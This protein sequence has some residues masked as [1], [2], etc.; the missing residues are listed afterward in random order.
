[1]RVSKKSITFARLL[2]MKNIT[3]TFIRLVLISLCAV[4]V[5]SPL[6]ADSK[7][8]SS[9]R[10]NEIN[11]G[12]RHPQY[13]KPVWGKKPGQNS[14]LYT[15]RNQSVASGITLNFNAMYYYGDVDM[16]DQAFIHGFQ[17]QNFSLGGSVH[18]GYLR[19]LGRHCNWRFTLGGG[20]LHGNDSARKETRTVGGITR[21][22]GK[23]YFKNIFL[24]GDAGVE[25]YP[26]RRAGFYLYAG[27]GLAVSF[28][29][30][31]FSNYGEPANNTVSVLPMLPLEIGYNF[32][33][34]GSFYLGVSVSVH[35]GLMDLANC[36]LDAWPL[37]STSKFQWGDG[38]FQIGLSFS[39]RW[40][41]CEACRVTR[42]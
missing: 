34:G 13:N 41:N 4:F 1:L 8:N 40:H 17:P 27:L 33:L 14:G 28:I 21:P 12:A 24:E 19:P 7:T 18:F 15:I 25:Y 22:A 10:K 5:V 37:R 39:Y 36:N 11:Y 42:W 16:L 23:G 31:D 6:F 38:Y 32:Y 30:Y 20:Y 26:F 29:N 2:K 9:N 3:N 35:Q